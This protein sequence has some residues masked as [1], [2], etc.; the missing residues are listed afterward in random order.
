MVSI[1]HPSKNSSEK[2][3]YLT[4]RLATDLGVSLTT[5][6]WLA[7]RLASALAQYP[8]D[9][10]EILAWND[11]LETPSPQDTQLHRWNET[12][13]SSFSAPMGIPVK[14]ILRET[15]PRVGSPSVSMV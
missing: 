9:R 7:R 15:P 6:A 8:L 3:G 12:S 4:R 14:G 1:P 2:F 5:D 10:L 13:T 11:Y